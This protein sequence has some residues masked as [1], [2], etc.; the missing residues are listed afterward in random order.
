M[1]KIGLT[2]ATILV[3]FMFVQQAEACSRVLW[4]TNGKAVVCGRTMDWE[5]PW[6]DYLFIFPRGQ[7]LDGGVGKESAEWTS[8]YGSVCCSIIPYAKKYG[9][10]LNDG[11]ADGMNEKGLAAHLLYLET[12]SYPKASDQPAVS[13]LRW[14]RY[15]LDNCKDVDEAVVAMRKIRI[16]PVKMSGKVFGV[17][18]AVEDPTGDSAIFEFIDGNLVIHHGKK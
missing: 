1:K 4:N 16:A 7:K 9:F 6:N 17:H 3:T 10:D 5:H 15:L 8:K 14:V 13:Y 2:L 18:V 11:V 12:S